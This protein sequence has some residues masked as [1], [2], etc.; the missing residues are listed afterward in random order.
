MLHRRPLARLFG[1]AVGIVLL[2]VSAPLKAQESGDI[3]TV[4]DVEVDVTADNS[5]AA[6]DR[7]ITEAQRKAFDTLYGR[8]S[9]EPGAKAP[10]LSDIE[11]ARLVQDFEVQRER[12]SAV[13]YL[14]TLTVRFRPTNVR[15]L[16][17]T[18]GASYVETRSK[19]VL[20]LPVY[21][22]AG[23]GPVLWEDRTPWR[24]AWENFPPPQGMVP[25]VVP[26]GELAD[27]ADIS[28]AT[29]L[30][31]NQAGL[32]A[33]AERYQASDVLVA[34]LG[35]RG[36]EPDPS[37]PNTVKLTRYA[38]DGTKRSDTVT[39]P[40][41]PGQTVDAYLAG[42]VAAV[43]TVAGREVAAGQ[44]RGGWAGTGDAGGGADRQ[45]ERLG[46]DET[47]ACPG[48]DGVARGSDDTDAG[49]GAGRALLSRQPR[50]SRQRPGAAGSEPDGGAASGSGGHSGG[51]AGNSGNAGAA[52]S[53]NGSGGS[54]GR[55]LSARSRVAVALDRFECAGSPADAPHPSGAEA[56][57]MSIP[58]LISLGRLLSVPLAVWLIL[59]GELGWAFWLFVA[60]GLSDAMDGFIARAFRSRTALGGYLDPIADKALLVSVYL[61]LGHAGYLPVWLVILVV[62]RDI[63]IVGG[64]LLLYT[65]KESFAMQPS[66]ISKVNTTMQIVLAALVLSTFGL[67]LTEPPFDL[68][69]ITATMI[70]VVA[71]T[72]A[73]SGLGYIV[74]GSRLLSR[75]GG[76]K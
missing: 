48:A 63:L 34:V 31:G 4:R 43:V 3:Y 16:L 41:A 7:A 61:A 73:W 28:A 17:Q 36:A 11:V 76:T 71:V 12:S 6:R 65:L 57:Y 59:V 35:V 72:T 14:A 25:I 52:C 29:A 40:A 18:K 75:L 26:Y 46:A 50:G 54:A 53:R 27:I 60:S 44:Y 39:V 9:P 58:N 20:V 74:T 70:W 56:R 19:P 32:S 23:K 55:R 1:L 30:E 42:G 24:A 51:A 38:A 47:P 66:F 5:A 64:V 33:I 49:G 69:W 15:T 67:D 22:A 21:Q 2:A 62:F 13:R 37:A 45:P 10:A 8:L 68:K